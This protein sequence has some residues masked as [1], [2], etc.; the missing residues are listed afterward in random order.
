[1]PFWWKRRR[2]WWWGRRRYRPRRR[3]Q[4]RRRRVY[5]RRRTRR[6]YKSHRRRRYKVRRKRAKIR[7][8]QW[9]PDS[10]RKCKI[11]GLG[12]LIIGAEGTQMNCYSTNKY[13][14]IP[15]KVPYGGGFGS[16]AFTLDYL[17]QEFNFHNNFWT[18]SNIQK[19]LVRY[20]G[21]KFTFY[22]HPEIDFIVSYNR[23]LPVQINKYTYPAIHPHQQLLEKHHKI[24]LSQKSK[25][26]GKYTV[27]MFI[28][29][30][31][32]MLNKWFFT[33][34]FS[35]YQLVYIQG[36][37][38]NF[39]NSYLTETSQNL[40]VN[41]LSPNPVFFKN[42]DWDQ[43][44]DQNHPYEPYTSIKNNLTFKYKEKG[45]V[46]ERQYP[47]SNLS[48]SQS[49]SY[50]NGWFQPFILQ[51]FEVDYG[52]VAYATIPTVAGRY[53]PTKD[54]GDGNLFYL[55][56]T[57][58]SG[59]EPPND[60]QLKLENVPLW[61]AAYGFLSYIKTIKSEEFF[62]SHIV[63]MK[64]TAIYC[65]TQIGACSYYAPIDIEYT[66]G[67]KPYEQAINALDKARWTPNV[68]WQLKTLNAIVESG[69][70][71][72]Q[73]N[74]Q[75]YS[76]WELKYKYKFYFK[77]GGPRNPDEQITDP[78]Q[79]PTFDV[80]DKLYKTIQITNPLKQATETILHPWDQRRGLITQRA[81]KRMCENLQT[82]TEFEISTETPK[83]KKKIQG[84][85]LQNPEE[86]LQELQQCLLS[87]C[88]EN[89][90][91]DQ[92]Q[93]LQQLIQQQQ[94]QQQLLKYNLV[95]LLTDLKNKQRQLQ[96]E[97]NML[98]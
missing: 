25:P 64:S 43:A 92:T 50:D 26:N 1:M 67:K 78:T 2:K 86:N 85:A 24:I 74:E 12:T 49:I 83:K 81:F 95:K 36:A 60:K 3:P 22:R 79:L 14:Y 93:D 98:N 54:K 97:A 37:A 91:Q 52:T 16:E 55:S 4:K 41:I 18:A 9:Q 65:A 70:F 69:P 39:R 96:L 82:D 38:C 10:I 72:P 34:P 40:L 59:W 48:Y 42:K 68:T 51:A 8:T 27:K 76:T 56:S 84:A 94:Q 53:N 62:K 57:L 20:T 31:K 63:V 45:N 77:W 87:L 47:P 13:D 6:P 19:D 30:P 7:L 80:P 33:Q 75:K 71:I 5:R 88:E 23:Q 35:E 44:R 11:I 89:T 15:P 58:T 66:Q 29:P 46:K 61:L 32:Q 73:L 90:Y 17:Y 28:K 21:C